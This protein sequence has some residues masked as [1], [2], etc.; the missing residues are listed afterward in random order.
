MK[1]KDP[2]FVHTL[3][4]VL[5]SVSMMFGFILFSAQLMEVFRTRE[6]IS[7]TARAYLLEMETTGYLSASRMEKLSKELRGCGLKEVSLQGSTV[8]PV[9]FGEQIQLVIT[10]KLENSIALTIPFLTKE[11]R[12]WTIPVK[13][14]YLSTAKH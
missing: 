12:M 7:Q 14:S 10:G 4:P 8:S 3:L 11:N 13:L 2:A 5:L 9:S 6:Q 1:K